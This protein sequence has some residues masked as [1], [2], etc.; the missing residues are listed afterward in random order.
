M[1][2]FQLTSV[3]SE[4][5]LHRDPNILEIYIKVPGASDWNQ[6]EDLS[7]PSKKNQIKTPQTKKKA[8][9]KYLQIVV[10]RSPY[11]WKVEL[12]PQSAVVQVGVP[13]EN[14]A[15][16][17]DLLGVVE[18]DITGLHRGAVYVVV[19]FELQG[20]HVEGVQ[21]SPQ[22]TAIGGE[23]SA[24]ALLKYFLDCVLCQ[25]QYIFTPKTHNTKVC[26]HLSLNSWESLSLCR[27]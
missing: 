27:K 17:A 1:L 18:V 2:H 25:P 7:L 13:D 5:D 23:V 3:L 14:H 8:R 4:N 10:A 11:N 19:H 6:L 26:F 15:L 12:N 24:D 16:H 9:K 20:K 22:L 21:H